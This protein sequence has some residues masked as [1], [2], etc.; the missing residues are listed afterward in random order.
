MRGLK[1]ER[2]VN[3]GRVTL[4]GGI[5][6]DRVWDDLAEALGY[7]GGSAYDY[8]CQTRPREVRARLRSLR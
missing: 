8:A 2:D 4:R 5:L 7:A 3:T 6:V 1:I